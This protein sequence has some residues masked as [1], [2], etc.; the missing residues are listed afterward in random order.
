M[1]PPEIAEAIIRNK[2]S[3]GYEETGKYIF[4]PYTLWG[5]SILSIVNL[6]KIMDR[7]GSDLTELSRRYPKFYQVKEKIP[8]ERK[9]KKDVVN[10]I[11]D[12]LEENPP[13]EVIKIIRVDGVKIIYP[14]GWLLIRASGT[15]DVVRIFSDAKSAKRARELVEWGKKLTRNFISSFSLLLR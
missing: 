6:L 7:E 15:E 8:V 12:Y 14:D 2:A 4:P 3:F 9:I 13:Q 11:G 5:D 1:G 10:K